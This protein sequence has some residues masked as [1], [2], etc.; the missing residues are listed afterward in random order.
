MANVHV[1][2]VVFDIL[3]TIWFPNGIRKTSWNFVKFIFS[4][5]A[6]LMLKGVS[7]FGIIPNL[8]FRPHCTLTFTIVYDS[9][10]FMFYF[11]RLTL[12]VHIFYFCFFYGVLLIYRTFERFIY[13][14]SINQRSHGFGLFQIPI[15]SDGFLFVCCRLHFVHGHFLAYLLFHLF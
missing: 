6:L 13:E 12:I 7:A 3:A 1:R 8:H 15:I 11:R 4:L 2:S 5:E 9:N 14:I 10:F